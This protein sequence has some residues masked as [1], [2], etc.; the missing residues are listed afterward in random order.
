MSEHEHDDLPAD[1][2][3]VERPRSKLRSVDAVGLMGDAPLAH[4]A[5]LCDQS[6]REEVWVR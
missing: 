2:P 4:A 5:R 1:R 6:P 3:R